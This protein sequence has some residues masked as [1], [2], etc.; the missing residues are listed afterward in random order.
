MQSD[1]MIYK[2][3]YLREG[4]GVGDPEICGW[5]TSWIGQD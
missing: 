3:Y 5:I 2:D 4:K 1:K